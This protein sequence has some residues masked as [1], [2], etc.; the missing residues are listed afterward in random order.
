MAAP[1]VIQLILQAKDLA[2]EALAR[3]KASAGQLPEQERAI[4]AKLN[5]LRTEAN[6]FNAKLTNDRIALAAIEKEKNLRTLLDYYKQGLISA[7]QYSS[8]VKAANEKAMAAAAE[9]SFFARI[10]EN[11]LALSAAIVGVWA[12]INKALWI[13]RNWGQPHYRRKSPSQM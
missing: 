6:E 4:N 11:W 3:F 10:K 8:G 13:M 7:E 1:E 9:P 2:T 12:L 5:Q